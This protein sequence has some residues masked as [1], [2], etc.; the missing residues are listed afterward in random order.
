[1]LKKTVALATLVS[2]VVFSC[3]CV[4]HT[5]TPLVSVK[6]EDRTKIK[7]SAVQVH[8]GEKTEFS[9][10]HVGRIK[11]DSVIG[12]IFVK[13]FTL[14][15]SKIKKP[16]SFETGSVAEIL[17]KDGVY[18]R[19]ARIITQNDS[20]VT[21]EGYFQATIPV[22][23]VD[24]VWISKIN[25]GATLGIIIGI[26]AIPVGIIIGILLSEDSWI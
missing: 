14:E 17:T 6:P 7:I 15:K 26:C 24:F 12:M 16:L 3:S 2:F 23:D 9:R 21:F 25:V 19:A 10:D 18:Y 11:G 4:S 1:M 8:S 22:T 13:N 5:K 20:S